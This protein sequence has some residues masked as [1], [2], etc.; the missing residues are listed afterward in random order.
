MDFNSETKIKVLYEGL[1]EFEADLHQ[2]VHTENNI[3]FPQAVR[4]EAQVLGE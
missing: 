3:L 4:L 2:H 1:R